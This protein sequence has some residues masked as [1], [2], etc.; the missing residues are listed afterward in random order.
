LYCDTLERF[1]DE[2]NHLKFFLEISKV[3]T[4]ITDSTKKQR[5]IQTSVTS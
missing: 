2:N 4:S 1:L 3:W 5:L